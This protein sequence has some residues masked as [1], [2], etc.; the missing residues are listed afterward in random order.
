MCYETLLPFRYTVAS[1]SVFLIK[2]KIAS[3]SKYSKPSGEWGKWHEKLCNV[4][5]DLRFSRRWPSKLPSSEHTLQSWRRRLHVFPKCWYISNRYSI[6]CQKM[7]IVCCVLVYLITLFV[8]LYQYCNY[9]ENEM[10][11]N[12]AF[13]Q[14][15]RNACITYVRKFCWEHPHW[16]LKELGDQC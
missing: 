11:W 16:K 5:W 15:M 8:F 9:I 13:I 1:W 3:I 10:G 12:V 2:N 14:N 6:T 4:L 7:A